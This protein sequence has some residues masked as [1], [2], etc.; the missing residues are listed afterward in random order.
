MRS[1]LDLASGAV[2][3]GLSAVRR[4]RVFHPRGDARLATVTISDDAHPLHVLAGTHDAIVRTSRGIGLPEPVPD[5]HGVAI[6]LL[7]AHGAGAHQDVLLVSSA[8]PM[9][10]RHVLVPVVEWIAEPMYS[11]LVRH[12]NAGGERFLVGAVRDGDDGF[13]LQTATRRSPWTVAGAVTMGEPLEDDA[14]DALRF[15]PWHTG[16]GI[17]PIGVLNRLRR[18]AYEGSQRARADTD[19]PPS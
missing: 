5:F 11:S 4:A 12:R 10:A 2:F 3:G 1:P 8:A 7:N 14:A 13:V 16:G 19:D 6:K 15:S 17:E 9:G 18:G